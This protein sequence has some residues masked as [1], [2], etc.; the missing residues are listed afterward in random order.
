MVSETRFRHT[1]EGKEGR[2]GSRNVEGQGR[3]EGVRERRQRGGRAHAAMGMAVEIPVPAFSRS[4]T[5][6]NSLVEYDEEKR[7]EGKSAF[8]PVDSGG[9]GG[10]S[11]PAIERPFLPQSK[12]PLLSCSARPAHLVRNSTQPGNKQ[13]CRRRGGGGR[14]EGS[15]KLERKSPF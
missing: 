7:C 14:G 12:Q 10:G 9:E 2:T 3:K 1:R 5:T 4:S 11:D 13:A 6:R 8:H 15:V